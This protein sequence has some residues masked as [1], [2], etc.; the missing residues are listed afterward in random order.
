VRDPRQIESNYQIRNNISSSMTCLYSDIDRPTGNYINYTNYTNDFSYNYINNDLSSNL[1]IL[2]DEP[3][4][5]FPSGQTLNRVISNERRTCG[6]SLDEIIGGDSYMSCS[7]CN[8][9]F[10]E[11]E[12]KNWLRSRRTCPTCRGNWSNYDIYVNIQT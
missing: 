12:I 5:I 4:N 2:P 7:S 11:Q 8:N 9:N 1:L 10:K 3:H 6:I